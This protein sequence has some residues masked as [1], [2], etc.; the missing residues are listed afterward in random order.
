M[1]ILVFADD[2]ETRN[3]RVGCRGFQSFLNL[4]ILWSCLCEHIGAHEHCFLIAF[5]KIYGIFVNLFA[6]EL[7]HTLGNTC[8][9]CHRENVS[10]QERIWYFKI[11]FVFNMAHGKKALFLGST[12]LQQFVIL[13]FLF[14]LLFL[15]IFFLVFFVFSFFLL[16]LL[17][18][19]FFLGVVVLILRNDNTA[20]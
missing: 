5:L 20:G 14:F 19:L 12:F 6:R 7:T 9:A 2:L 1:L 15:G 4:R 18:H 13:V 10:S 16:I 11:P 3:N 17:T 8:K